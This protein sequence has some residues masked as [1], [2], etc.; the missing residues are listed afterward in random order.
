MRVSH[1]TENALRLSSM[2]ESS[3]QM[4]PLD[5]RPILT[6]TAEAYRPL[7]EKNGNTLTVN[8]ADNLPPVYGSADLLIQVMANLLSNSNVHTKNGEIGIKTEMRN[9]NGEYVVVTVTDN[10][11]GIS[12]ELLPHMFRRNITGASG[13]G[14]GLSISKEIITSHNGTIQIESENG[15]GTSVYDK[16]Q[17][18]SKKNSLFFKS[19]LY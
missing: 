5:I 18:L 11:S 6:T 10:G 2:Q 14:I 13:T 7:L 8:I 1:I 9:E 15:K 4:K 12:P 16:S 19:F 3:R 17:A